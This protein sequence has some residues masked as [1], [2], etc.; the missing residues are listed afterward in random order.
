[1]RPEWPSALQ[2]AGPTIPSAVRPW[3]RWKRLTARLGAGAEDAV[4]GDAERALEVDHGARLL[5]PPPRARGAGAVCAARSAR[6]VAGPTIPS[7]VR[8]WRRWKRL[9]ARLVAGPKMPSACRPS[10]RWTLATR[11]PCEPRLSAALGR[12]R[13]RRAGR[14]PPRRR[15]CSRGRARVV[16]PSRPVRPSA[17]DCSGRLRGELTGS[18]TCATPRSRRRF[19]PAADPGRFGSPVRRPLGAGDS[20]A[21]VVSARTPPACT[22]PC[23]REDCG[24]QVTSRRRPVSTS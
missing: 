6:H 15:R 20:A 12:A 5:A 9:T 16:Y 17:Y 14:R 13:R 24:G 3:L 19:A 8:P 21:V 10:Q 18:R 22:I 1:M 23:K 7:A 11:A 2:V 4:G